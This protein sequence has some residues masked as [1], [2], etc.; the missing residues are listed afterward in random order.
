MTCNNRIKR[1]PSKVCIGHLDLLITLK[2]KT[3]TATNNSNINSRIN[4]GNSQDVWAFLK[5]AQGEEIFDGINM[6]GK[7]THNFYIRYNPQ[8]KIDKTF[9]VEFE[10]NRYNIVEILENLEGQRELTL[11]KCSISGSTQLE[12]TKL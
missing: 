9:I 2:Q 4:L 11:L 3:K 5:S 8:F 12:S 7:I 1:R 10:N 6:I